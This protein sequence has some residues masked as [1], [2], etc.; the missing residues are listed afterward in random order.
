VKSFFIWRVIFKSHIKR[1]L[2]VRGFIQP[3]EDMKIKTDLSLNACPA[4]YV[5]VAT[6][7]LLKS[8]LRKKEKKNG[9]YVK[10]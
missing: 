7:S 2:K 8:T 3:H 6:E 4:T 9:N 5:G 1:L 10:A